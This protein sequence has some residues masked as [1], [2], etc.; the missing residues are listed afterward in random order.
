MIEASQA[1]GASVLLTGI[2]LQA[3]RLRVNRIGRYFVNL[4]SIICYRDFYIRELKCAGFGHGL[5]FV[6]IEYIGC[7]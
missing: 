4:T 5:C 7:R 6:N 3:V 2:M 1:I